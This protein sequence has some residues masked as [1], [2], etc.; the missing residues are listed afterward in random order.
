[1]TIS[2][3]VQSSA[4]WNLQEFKETGKGERSFDVPQ[5][6]T[7]IGRT[8]ASSFSV[9]VASI[10]K[11][12]AELEQIGDRLFLRDL[13]STNGTYVNGRSI[14]GTIEIVSGD[15][16]QFAAAAF[17]ATCTVNK[18]NTDFAP[19]MTITEGALNWAQALVQFDRLM[20]D[21]AVTPFYQKIIT[22]ADRK[23]VGYEV[24]ARSRMQG[25]EN[26]A[27]LFSIAERLEQEESLSELMRVEGTRNTQIS[28]HGTSIFL[29]THPKEAVTDRL[30]RSLRELRK[31]EPEKDI[32]IEIHEGG[33]TRVNEMKRLR[34]VLNEL[35]MKL[36]YDD[37][38]AGQARLVELTEVPP[39]VL[40]F[41]MGLIRDIDKAPL[42]RR[43][44]VKALIDIS[45][46]LGITPLAEGVETEEEH[47]ACLD[48]GFTQ[49]QGYLYGRPSP[50]GE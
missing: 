43:A 42:P 22:L 49:G 25:L 10:S 26:P 39:D 15:L 46:S 17:R 36:A 33:V 18:A 14:E 34:S 32:T 35:G 45:H 38:G 11:N 31:R 28:M 29:N 50:Q 1:M 44:M 4:I 20:S 16:I 24:L 30:I 13:G 9:P 48:L 40:K 23:V 27:Q 19:S 7:S 12:H 8:T 47:Q 5:G 2:L 6:I 21:K 41:D 37:F 3:S